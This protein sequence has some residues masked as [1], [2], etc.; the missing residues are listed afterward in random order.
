MLFSLVRPITN[1][2]D[3]IHNAT[4]TKN[5]GEFLPLRGGE[6]IFLLKN[7]VEKIYGPS[8]TGNMPPDRRC[9]PKRGGRPTNPFP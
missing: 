1:M 9:L 2:V 5:Q 6:S 8:G 3:C 4:I 7:S